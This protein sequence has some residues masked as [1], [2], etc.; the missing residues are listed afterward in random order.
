MVDEQKRCPLV[1]HQ[2]TLE[3]HPGEFRAVLAA[4]QLA[5]FPE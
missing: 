2:E 5:G 4:R 1:C 3:I